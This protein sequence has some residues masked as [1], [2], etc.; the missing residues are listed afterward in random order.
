M[1]SNVLMPQLG[2]SIAEGTIVRWKKKVGDAIDRDEPLFEISTDKVDAEIPSPT[3]GVLV[4]IRVQAG[5]TVPVDSVVAV[6]DQ[7]QDGKMPVAGEPPS[8]GAMS[9][10]AVP[11]VDVPT[12]TRDRSARQVGVSPLVRKLVREHQVDLGSIKGTGVGGRVTKADVLDYMKR[13]RTAE[14]SAQATG[15][16]PSVEARRVEPMSVMRRRIADHMVRSR[17][18]S[19]HAHTVF[20]VDFSR[21][22][23]LRAEKAV[24]Y[25]QAGTKLTYLTFI[26]KAVIDAISQMPIINASVDKTGEHVVYKRD[27]NLGVAI[28]LDWGLVVPVIHRAAELS[29]PDLSAAFIE[30]SSRARAKQLRPEDV[31]DG[32]FTITNP[33]VF[34]SIFGMPIINQPQAAILCVGAIEKRPVVVDDAIVTRHHGYLTLGFDHRLLDGA[35][36]DRFMS[37][38]KSGLEEFN[39][40]LL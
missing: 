20:D 29:L 23:Q 2:E 5:E 8:A 9:L 37:I 14:A 25:K 11:A 12:P 18:T 21:V 6:V 32:T 40:S 30:L 36:A 31:Q 38:V 15:E 34:G 7:I 28:A 35:M 3:A 26:A 33:G 13:T 27:V 16:V 39:A 22:T 17:R 1:V 24:A 10:S 19:A 4:E